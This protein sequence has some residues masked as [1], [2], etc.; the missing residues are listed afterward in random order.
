MAIDSIRTGLLLL[1]SVLL[2]INL[3][4]PAPDD[5]QHLV[6]Q[7]TAGLRVVGSIILRLLVLQN[8]Q[9]GDVWKA[10]WE[11]SLEVGWPIGNALACVCRKRACIQYPMMSHGPCNSSWLSDAAAEPS[12]YWEDDAAW[13]VT[14]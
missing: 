6:V 14:P 1:L 7:P 12:D 9:I 4:H 11:E 5:V 8:V 13:A 2:F 10:S 3:G